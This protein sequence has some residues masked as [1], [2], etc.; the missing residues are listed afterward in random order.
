MTR[1]GQGGNGPGLVRRGGLQRSEAER[2]RTGGDG[3]E[4]RWAKQGGTEAE[5]SAAHR[6]RFLDLDP[7]GAEG[8]SGTGQ[9]GTP[10]DRLAQETTVP[11]T[12]QGIV[13]TCPE[14]FVRST[15]KRNPI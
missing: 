6:V 11:R 15:N 14:H 9:D 2:G 7:Q 1:A 8:R 5:R 13:H 10:T 3:K 12:F 4:L